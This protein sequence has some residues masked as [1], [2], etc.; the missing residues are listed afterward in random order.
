MLLFE[1][2]QI[3]NLNMVMAKDPSQSAKAVAMGQ[4]T[5]FLEAGV[6]QKLPTWLQP[7]PETRVD[8]YPWLFLVKI[9]FCF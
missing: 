9:Q 6:A 2:Y 3:R 1:D 5:L 8:I 4:L 7:L